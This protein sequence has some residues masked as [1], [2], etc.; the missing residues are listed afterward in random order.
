MALDFGVS[1]I[2]MPVFVVVHVVILLVAL[3]VMV[4]AFGGGRKPIGAA[5]LLLAIGEVF[6]LFYHFEWWTFLLSHTLAEVMVLL[7]IIL[8]FVGAVKRP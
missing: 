2:P 1:D 7:A 8:V 6:Y 3:F 4:R 5:M